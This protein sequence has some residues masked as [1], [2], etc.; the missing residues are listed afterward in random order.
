MTS[1]TL[2]LFSFFFGISYQNDFVC[3][4]RFAGS[5]GRFSNHESSSDTDFPDLETNFELNNLEWTNFEWA[6][7]ELAYFE[8]AYF[9]LA[10]FELAYYEWTSYDWA[11]F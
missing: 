3:L 1:F 10:Y 11:N 7:F 5:F 9:E 6:N 4:K 2:D 8:L